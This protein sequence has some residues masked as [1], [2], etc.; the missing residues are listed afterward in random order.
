M[1]SNA[2]IAVMAF[3]LVF[4]IALPVLMVLFLRKR[5]GLG[6]RPFLI[7]CA[8]WLVF[9]MGLEQ[10]MHLAVMKSPAGDA[11]RGSMWLTA[12][13]GGLAAGV[14][15]ESGR[16]LAM[17]TLLKRSHSDDRNSIMYGAGHGGVEA[18]VLLGVGMVNNIIYSVLINTGNTA[19]LTAPL[20]P[21]QAGQVQAVIDQLISTSASS[22]LMAPVERISAVIFHILLSVIVWFAVTRRKFLLFPLA[23]FL[24]FA[25]DAG[26]VLL[27]KSGMQAWLVEVFIFLFVCVIAALT[28]LL[29]KKYTRQYE[30]AI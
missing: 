29:W 2:S 8:V 1:V 4:G 13:Y 28:L 19:V 17:S 27:S 15:E 3:N 22:F 25:M 24:H 7:G 5:Y 6:Y 16:F 26:A 9:T 14:F 12:L 10:L 20:N 18:F 21:E 23:I 11:I 30:E